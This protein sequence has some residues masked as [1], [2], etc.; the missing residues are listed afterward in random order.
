M[1]QMNPIF[2][3]LR[4]P[5]L[6][7]TPACIA[8]GLGMVHY[9]GAAIDPLYSTL[10]MVGALAAHTA[11]NAFNEYFDFRSGLDLRTCRTPFS[12]GSGT[13]PKHPELAS[14]TLAIGLTGATF[15]LAVGFYF[16]VVQGPALLPVGLLGLVLVF[17]Y[18]P[19]LTRRPWLCLV[20]PGLGFGPCMV[21]GTQ[22]ALTGQY[23]WAGFTSSLV[24][25]FLAN[26]LLLLNQFPDLEAD[27]NV[28]RN[29]LPILIGRRRSGLI[30]GLFFGLALLALGAGVFLGHLPTASLLGYAGLA[31]GVPVLHGVMRHPDSIGKL[32]PYLGLN[33]AVSVATPVLTAVGAFLG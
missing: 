32:L 9:S 16:W 28:G 12:G 8:L 2:G 25:F 15:A 20:A 26:N 3:P 4:P 1:N 33:V 21:L 31:A 17:F 23:S 6:I 10:I 11:V 27:R 5:F 14:L 13:L 7:L 29:N 22:A 18:T 24:P 19:W 30:Y